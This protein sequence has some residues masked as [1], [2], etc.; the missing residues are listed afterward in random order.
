MSHD[1]QELPQEVAL[2]ERHNLAV[3]NILSVKDRIDY[4]DPDDAY[5][6]RGVVMREVGELTDLACALLR[7]SADGQF[8]N[9]HYIDM[10]REIHA[11]VGAKTNGSP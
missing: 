2:W 11:A 10:L 1:D 5:R 4:L 7:A 3:N 6:L 8:I 9:G